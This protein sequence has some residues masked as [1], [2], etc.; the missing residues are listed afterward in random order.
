MSINV[1]CDLCKTWFS[2][3]EEFA[4][5]RWKCPKCWN[6][7]KIPKVKKSKIDEQNHIF[8]NHIY[9][10]KQKKVAINEKYYIKNE[11]NEDILFAV[12]KIYFWKSLLSWGTSIL[13]IFLA[14]QL[15]MQLSEIYAILTIFLWI[16]AWITLWIYIYPKRHISFLE[17]ENHNEDSPI[18]EIK[19]D[20]KFQFITKT[21]SLIDNNWDILCKFRKNTFTDLLK[22]TW[23]LEF[24]NNHIVVTEDNMFLAILRKYL[25]YIWPLIRINFV[26]FNNDSRNEIWV[27][28]RKFELFDNYLLDLSNDTSYLVPRKYAIALAVLLDTWERR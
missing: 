24:E 12:R 2:L 18:F 4:W 20:A 10:I 22:K 15:S 17:S 8:K 19:E 25:P 5:K 1:V 23:H 13:I 14:I 9:W 7:L 21:Y 6:I 28:K 27:F 11:Q 16:I 3:S 26:F